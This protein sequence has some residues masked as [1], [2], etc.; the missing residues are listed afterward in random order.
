MSKSIIGI[1]KFIKFM[2]DDDIKLSKKLLF[3]VPVIYFI[4]PIDIIPD[5]FFPIAGWLDDAAVIIL[6]VPVLK[7]ILAKYSPSK[8]SENNHDSKNENNSKD[9]EDVID[10]NDDDYEFK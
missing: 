10:I 8:S 3:A 5:Y 4:S 1:Y 9:A 2:L 7:N 6:M